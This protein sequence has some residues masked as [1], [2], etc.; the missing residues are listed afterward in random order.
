[1]VAD[2]NGDLF[3]TT[4]TGGA[5]NKGTVPK[6]TNSGFATTPMITPIISDILW[7]NASSGDAQLWNP[8]G[9]G[10]FS[11]QDLGV[12]SGWQIEGTGDFNG[13][14][15][16][17]ILWQ[18]A[19]SGDVQLWNPNGSGG[20]SGQDLGVHVGWQ[21]EGTGD[22]NGSSA[23]GI[24][25]Q[26]ASSGDVVRWNSNGSGG[27]TGQDLGVHAGW[28]IEDT[29]DFN[30]SGADGIL[31]QNSSS[32]AA[33]LWNPNGSGGFTGQDLGV[34]PGWQ[35]EGTGDFNASSSA[36]TA[37]C[38]KTRRVGMVQL[39]GTPMARAASPG[40]TW[41]F[42]PVGILVELEISNGKSGAD[43]ILWQNS[44]SGGCPA[45]EL[46]WLGRLSPG[47]TWAF[48]PVGPLPNRANSAA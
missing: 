47:K 44:S 7:Q 8:N 13:S 26:N 6:I 42:T 28:Q 39:C 16:D 18:N 17:G 12:H 33:Q 22:F 23:D 32:G 43:G 25:W 36:E 1:M 30:G 40:K 31:W 19:S 3:G 14:G 45:L 11:G 29:G 48:T 27:F 5:N 41:A 38:G 9:L 34:H 35:I 20:F 10:G 4:Q 24:L 2:A 37:S 15:A 21:I 46:E